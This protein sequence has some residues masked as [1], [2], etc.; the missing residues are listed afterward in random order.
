VIRFWSIL[1]RNRPASSM[2]EMSRGSRPISP[3]Q[4]ASG[5]HRT[6][7]KNNSTEPAQWGPPHCF[8]GNNYPSFLGFTDAPLA[9][10]S[11]RQF[12]L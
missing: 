5:R 10:D 2:W 6:V 1:P 12:F 9:A 7:R 4:V 11:L 8:R 3:A